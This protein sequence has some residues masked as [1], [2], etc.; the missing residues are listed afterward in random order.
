MK[1]QAIRFSAITLAVAALV[2]AAGQVM[3]PRYR[4]AVAAGALA[5]ALVQ[6]ASFWTF[7][8]WLFPGRMWEGYG[9][10]LLV[11]LAVFGVAAFWAVPALG[12]PFAATLFALAGVFWVS[13]MVE[14]LFLK[15]RT[16][17][18]TQ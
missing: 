10:G 4:G 8:V 17:N 13:T 6:V 15:A 5:A 18:S 1:T 2:A 11:R 9:L 12:L 16:S 7:A 3:D 14:P